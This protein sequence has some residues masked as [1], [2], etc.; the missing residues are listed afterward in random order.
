MRRAAARF[1]AAALAFLCAAAG[2]TAGEPRGKECVVRGKRALA[3]DAQD[4]RRLAEFADRGGLERTA[5][6]EWERVLAAEPGDEAAR[7]RLR[8]VRRGGEWIRDDASW[9]IVTSAAETHPDLAATYAAKRRAEFERPSS[10]RHREVAIAC[11]A[12]GQDP[13]GDAELRI[14]AANDPGDLW[15]RLALGFV[16]DPVDGWVTPAVRARRVAE[17]VARAG[18]ARLKALRAEPTVDETPSPRSA[19]AGTAL[20]AWRLRE[21]RL[22]TDLPDAEAPLAIEGAD[23]AARWFREFL[24]LPPGAPVLPGL[25]TFVVLTTPDAYRRVVDAAPGLSA[26]ERQFAARLGSFPLPH[27]ADKGPWE[28][29]IER[30]EGVSAADACLHYAVHF[31]MQ[32]RFHVEAQEAWLYEG[33]AAY[34]AVRLQEVHGTWCVRLEPTSARVGA[35][36]IPEDAREWPEAVEWLA[37]ARDDF[38]MKGLVGVSLNGLDGPMLAKSWSMLRWLLEEHP[39]EARAFLDAKRAGTATPKALEAATGLSLDDFDEAWRDA[40]ME[41]GGE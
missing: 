37:R 31:L 27:A 34:A 30:P 38:P 11:R 5:D 2:A 17:A 19:A 6:S 41:Q 28:V 18:V 20:R 25:G 15:S 9:A 13:L 12:A 7:K 40:V 22:E 4:L 3:E 23:L 8:Y 39:A 32:A 36:E 29:V 16:P 24:G 10:M 35:P 26:S 14:A 21:W 33:F 1:C